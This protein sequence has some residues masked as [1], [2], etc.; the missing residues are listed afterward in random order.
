[1]K[2]SSIMS[3][4]QG[5]VFKHT[6]LGLEAPKLS[7]PQI[8]ST[9]LGIKN[10]SGDSVCKEPVL[11]QQLIRMRQVISSKE[12]LLY[13]T[14]L[15]SMLMFRCLLRVGQV[16]SSSHTIKRSDV[17]L[18]QFGLVLEVHSSKTHCTQD[19]PTVLPVSCTPRK[20]YCI[21]CLLK[22]FMSKCY[23]APSEPLFSSSEILVFSYSMFM[24]QFRTLLR[25][26]GISVNL[27]SHSLRY[28]GASSMSENGL[29]VLDIKARGRWKLACVL[30]YI[31]PSMK[32]DIQQD[33]L[34]TE[35]LLLVLVTCT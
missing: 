23:R 30:R 24:S 13:L 35:K 4:L 31:R 10:H 3:Y 25:R 20:R 14:W 9:L 28:G 12:P 5:V 29:P 7:H 18:T 22:K 19:K 17:K 16:V 34:W 27:T 33:K 8:K 15:A 26:A 32:H 1:M 2:A 21:V 6:V 11:I